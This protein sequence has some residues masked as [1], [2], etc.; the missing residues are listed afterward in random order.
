M[1]IDAFKNKM[2]KEC[3]KMMMMMLLMILGIKMVLLI[4]KS[5]IDYFFKKTKRHQLGISISILISQETLSSSGSGSLAEKKLKR[6]KN[7]K[8]NK[9]Q[10][11]LA[12]KGL[13]D[14]KDKI[15]NM[16]Q[17]EMKFEHPDDIVDIVEK[18]LELIK[19]KKSKN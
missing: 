11:N 5:F 8:I 18:I 13:K 4:I 17:D 14:L 15:Q 3:L 9:I 2:K 7:E 6:T 12:R 1:I 19:N 16:P 10:A